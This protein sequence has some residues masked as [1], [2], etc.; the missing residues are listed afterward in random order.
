MMLPC[1]KSCPSNHPLVNISP[2]GSVCA[3]PQDHTSELLI[4][5]FDEAYN[6]NRGEG[7]SHQVVLDRR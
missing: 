5:A 4:K 1:C 3:Q 7:R 6:G 2:G